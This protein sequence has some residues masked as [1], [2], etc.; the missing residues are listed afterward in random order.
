MAPDDMLEL[1]D[2]RGCR[3]PLRGDS[4]VAG[5]ATESDIVLPDERASR[6]QF[7]LRR[8]PAGWEIRDPGSTNGTYVNGRRLRPNEAQLLAPGDRLA[9]GSLSFMV[10][11]VPSPGLPAPAA[12]H[13][14]AAAPRP[15]SGH[16]RQASAGAGAFPAWQWV[17]AAWVVAG[18]VLVGVGAFQP[19]VR[20]DVQFT[21]SQAPGGQLLEDLFSAV[22]Q[23]AGALLGTQPLVKSRT[24]VLEGMDTFGPLVLI[25][26]A[27]ALLGLLV[28]WGMKLSRS[29]FPGLIYILTALLPVGLIYVEMQ[30]FNSVANQ[31][32]L[33]GV[34]LLTML[35]GATRLL[36][37]KV[38]PL[39]GLY[40]TGMGLVCVLLAGVLR[41]L[42]PLFAR[43]DGM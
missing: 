25:A 9:V 4:L 14:P 6:R 15:L 19:W 22:E 23:A 7:M 30:R 3:M 8:T 42:F 33:F 43:K 39:T 10:Q 31:E 5:R 29:S 20:I 38:T 34:N 2:S 17:V 28:D 24:I 40:L 26:A 35:E 27:L 41:C 13:P 32:I 21:L 1:V 11:A 36:A 12:P 37:P 18:A 16:V